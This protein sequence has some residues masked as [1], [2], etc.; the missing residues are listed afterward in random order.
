MI[1]LIQLVSK[2]TFLSLSDVVF[3][4]VCYY[5]QKLF[6][7]NIKKTAIAIISACLKFIEIVIEEAA[8][9]SLPEL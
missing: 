2:F 8:A 7:H 1:N 6:S 3:C 5:S 9:L 4:L